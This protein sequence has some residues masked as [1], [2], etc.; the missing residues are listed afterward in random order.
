MRK[1]RILKPTII[2]TVLIIDAIHVTKV[3]TSKI[4]ILLAKVLLYAA[5]YLRLQRCRQ[6]S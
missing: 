3:C 5:L 6:K 4:M 2:L 1:K